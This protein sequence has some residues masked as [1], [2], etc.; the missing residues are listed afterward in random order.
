MTL[1]SE[2]T[3][4]EL[5]A[6]AETVQSR[7]GRVAAPQSNRMGTHAFLLSI[8]SPLSCVGSTDQRIG[9]RLGVRTGGESAS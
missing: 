4:A 6:R 2:T 8:R 5:D 7:A 3:I 1:T 9:A